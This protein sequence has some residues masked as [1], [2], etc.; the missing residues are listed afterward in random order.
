MSHMGQYHSLAVRPVFLV[1]AGEGRAA[2][3]TGFMISALAKP[4]LAPAALVLFV[5]REWKTI[6]I[7]WD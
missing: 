3:V 4:V 7:S 5:R 2:Q 1:L 6:W